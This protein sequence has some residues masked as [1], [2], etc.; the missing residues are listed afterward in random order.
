MCGVLLNLDVCL[1]VVGLEVS[2]LSLRARS[3]QFSFSKFII[4]ILISAVRNST[5][6]V[7]TGFSYNIVLSYC[8]FNRVISR[9]NSWMTLSF[10][11]SL[12]MLIW[13]PFIKSTRISTGSASWSFLTYSTSIPCTHYVAMFSLSCS[14]ILSCIWFAIINWSWVLIS[15][16]SRFISDFY[17]AILVFEMCLVTRQ[18]TYLRPTNFNSASNFVYS[19]ILT[20]SF[21][22]LFTVLASASSIRIPSLSNSDFILSILS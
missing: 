11:S 5:G 14:S 8:S 19:C 18:A 16:F 17:W 13:L 7:Y 3:W 12:L 9:S 15:S 21:S 22:L 2:L 6:S 10:F 4:C 1:E 20:Y